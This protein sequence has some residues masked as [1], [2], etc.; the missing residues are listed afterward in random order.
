MS[1]PD[2]SDTEADVLQAVQSEDTADLYDLAR[3]VGVG[4]RAVQDAVR[5]LARHDFVH[6]SGR[7]VRCTN[8]GDQ[9]VRTHS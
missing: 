8:A 7:H 6:A 1:S 9:W 3:A 5:R 2:L 4:P